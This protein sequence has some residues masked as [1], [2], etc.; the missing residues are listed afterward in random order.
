M[1]AIRGL[2]IEAEIKEQ[3]LEA[4]RTRFERQ[5]V[6]GEDHAGLDDADFA[7]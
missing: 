1:S 2:A 6:R 4:E 3:M 5:M 7:I